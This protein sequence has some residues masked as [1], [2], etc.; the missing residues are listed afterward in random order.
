MTRTKTLKR[1]SAMLLTLSMLSST[2]SA[3]DN[4]IYDEKFIQTAHTTIDYGATAVS[5]AVWH[6]GEIIASGAEGIYS[7]NQNTALT[8]SHLFGIGSVS[9]MY[10][11][12][13]ILLLENEGKISLDAPVTEYLPEFHM[14]DERYKNITVRMLLNHSA[15]LMGSTFTNGMLN[16]DGFEND[17]TKYLLERL[18]MQKLQA[19][20]GEYSVYCND[21]FTLAELII[22][23][24]SGLTY[25]EFLS[26]NIIKP[27]GLENT[28][29]PRD[30]FDKTRL[31]KSY[32]GDST[33]P[34]PT[35]TLTV[36][37]TGGI[38][39]T[40]EDLATFGGSFTN[41]NILPLEI[42]ELTMIDEFSKGLAPEDFEGG[43]TVYGLGW[44]SVSVYPFNENDMQALVKGGDTTSY[45]ASL[46]VI[47]E[48]ELSVAVLSSGGSSIFNQS[49]AAT[50]A[51]EVLN[52]LE[53]TV[54]ES[55]GLTEYV[56]AEMPSNYAN[57]SGKYASSFGVFDVSFFENKLMMKDVHGLVPTVYNYSADGSFRDV[58]NRTSVMPIVEENGNT[59]LYFKS[60]SDIINM[61]NVYSSGYLYQKLPNN[62]LSETVAEKWAER[63]GKAYA[64]INEKYTSMSYSLGGVFAGVSTEGTDGYLL[65]NKIVDEN[66]AVPVLQIPGTAS[67]DMA[68]YVFYERGGIEHM[69]IGGNVY[70]DM[71]MLD[72]IF[73]G[74]ASCTISETGE[75]R[76]Y[77]GG[78]VEGMSMTVTVPENSA[79]YV[80]NSQLSPVGGSSTS[81]TVTVEIPT[82]G[83]MV[84]VGD[85]GAR[86]QISV[87]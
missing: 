65:A 40:A 73:V 85:V 4:E 57:F 50:M 16:D 30:S 53:I 52:S 66:T 59:Y 84:F 6:E 33:T 13:A 32:L 5:Y 87:S 72:H 29:T 48:H 82:G 74:E 44:D 25:T 55:G 60:Y 12:A 63:E 23:R 77:Y 41:D 42:D 75:A 46:L 51:M 36:I 3:V 14:D 64:L 38:Y 26:E 49:A 80:Y 67:R 43:L 71:T 56:S 81:G 61:A 78:D 76:W 54:E 17:S 79:F 83:V 45:H 1:I 70:I 20:P 22:E 15:G 9:K 37:G 2:V 35:E 7:K 69:Q 10:T 39:S 86:F 28:F 24:V 68:E 19:D 34:L 8:E 58:T 11:T 27:L 47:P 18:S 21:G 62:V 31:V